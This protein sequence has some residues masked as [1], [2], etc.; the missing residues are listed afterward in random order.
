ML[1]EL[2]YMKKAFLL[3]AVLVLFACSKQ[4]DINAGNMLLLQIDFMT[5]DFEGG[6][7]L[8]VTVDNESLD[9]IPILVDYKSPGDFGNITLFY[10]PSGEMIFDGS[11]IWMGTG[12][13]KYPEHFEALNKFSTMETTIE[14]PDPSE[15]Q[16]VFYNL[17]NQPIDYVSIW[18]S[19]NNLEIVSDYLKSNKNIGLFLYTPSVGVGDPYE[20][21]WFVILNK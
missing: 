7:E 12:Q 1:N 15:F 20:W 17:Y 9:T 16:I 8:M 14:Q 11:I 3:I 19:I 21:N 4:D 2:K 6:A 10:Q 5:Y 18:G 13:I